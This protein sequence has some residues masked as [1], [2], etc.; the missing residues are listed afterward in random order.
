MI[1]FDF[2]DLSLSGLK[3]PGNF[4]YIF[5]QFSHLE[6]KLKKH[7]VYNDSIA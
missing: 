1:C 7:V 6:N 3:I 2:S 5:F 4:L